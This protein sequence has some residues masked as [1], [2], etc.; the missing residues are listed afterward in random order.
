MPYIVQRNQHFYVVAYNDCDP[1]T[2]QE[3]RRRHRA[4]S[5]RCDAE[6]I[7]QRLDAQLSSRP[8]QRSFGGFMSTTWLD[9]KA[10]LTAPTRN[11]YRWMIDH[12][13]SP[14]IG[15]I[16]LNALRPADLDACYRDLIDNGGRRNQGLSAK[17]V[18]EIHRVISNA[19]DLAVDRQLL[20]T[21]PARRARPPRRATRS[22][23]PAIW[24]AAQLGEFLDLTKT[25]RLHAALHLVAHTGIRRGELAGLNW[26]DLDAESASLSIVRTR[27][28]TS[29][30]TVEAP[31]KTRT[32]RRRIDLDANTTRTLRRWQRRLNHEGAT[33]D[34][35]TPMFLN[36][37]HRT[38]SPGSFSQLFTR[39][40]AD[41][42]L[43]KVRFHD[44]RHTHPSLLVDA[45]APIK[46]VS[47][48][49]GH[50]HPGFTMHTYQHLLPGMGAAAANQF[51]ELITASRQ[52]TR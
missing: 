8:R 15:S 21:N 9:S 17:T 10:V 24:T 46:V 14:R 5:N 50:A 42:D 35:T 20:D 52:T 39:S 37:H 38:P 11:R 6:A 26:G 36:R 43:P 31:V 19:L 32:S 29:G 40:V 48:R 41:S 49:L 13:I 12:N 30:G 45:G 22:T 3:R 44:L 51:A 25:K 16:R 1:I 27:Q 7:Q 28:V 23:V 47:E 34:S 2:G 33:I 4:G 18:L